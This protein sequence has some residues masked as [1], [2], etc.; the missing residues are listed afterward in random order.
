MSCLE[1]ELTVRIPIVKHIA[2]VSGIGNLTQ[3]N[4]RLQ[5]YESKN[6]SFWIRVE[7]AEKEETGNRRNMM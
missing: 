4:S 7:Q 1:L 3:D 2:M 5:R 6:K